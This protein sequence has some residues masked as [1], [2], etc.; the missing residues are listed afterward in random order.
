MKN[1]K[2]LILLQAKKNMIEIKK[3]QFLY[4]TNKANEIKNQKRMLKTLILKQIL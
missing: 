1:I 3:H 4:K 2:K